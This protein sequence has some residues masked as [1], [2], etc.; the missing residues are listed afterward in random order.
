[1]SIAGKFFKNLV[2]L[3]ADNNTLLHTKLDDVDV[4]HNRT[5]DI[6]YDEFDNKNGFNFSTY[7]EISVSEKNRLDIR[8]N[9]KQYDFNKE[10]SVSFVIPKNY[11]RT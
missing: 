5:A 6:T 7:R 3:S 10:L 8:L 9:Y 2:T 11:K 4:A 1:L